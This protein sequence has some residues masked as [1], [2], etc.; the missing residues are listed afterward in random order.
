MCF[1]CDGA[2]VLKEDDRYPPADCRSPH[3]IP[4]GDEFKS[5]HQFRNCPCIPR[6]RV[7]RPNN[8]LVVHRDWAQHVLPER[9]KIEGERGRER[10]G[11]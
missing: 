3:L 8:A 2:Y 5:R 6:F 9:E 10:D 1:V 7:F 4:Q 11:T